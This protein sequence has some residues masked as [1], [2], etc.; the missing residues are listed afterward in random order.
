MGRIQ[1]N[2]DS[3]KTNFIIVCIDAVSGAFSHSFGESTRN[4][5]LRR[6]FVVSDWKS[7]ARS[8]SAWIAFKESGG[9]SEAVAEA[10]Y[11][12][13]VNITMMEYVW[14][15]ALKTWWRS[16]IGCLTETVCKF[17]KQA[18]ME[19][20]YRWIGPAHHWCKKKKDRFQLFFVTLSFSVARSLCMCRVNL[21]R[22]RSSIEHRDE[23]CFRVSMNHTHDGIGWYR[24]AL[25][26][27]VERWG[28]RRPFHECRSQPTN[29]GLES[30][31][32]FAAFSPFFS[33]G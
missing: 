33:F 10:L 30:K 16:P 7:Q 1:A 9:R 18:A 15:K 19:W 27:L 24:D 20:N 25:W 13:I 14:G 32:E 17:R 31:K 22:K 29:E 21:I 28:R 12:E 4:R 6:V 3:W 2:D 8:E 5:M 26:K 23:S 11:F